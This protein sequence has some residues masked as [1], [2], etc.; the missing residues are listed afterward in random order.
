MRDH[1]VGL[2]Q[3]FGV[4]TILLGLLLA[5]AFDRLSFLQRDV[6]IH[7]AP[8]EGLLAGPVLGFT[9]ALGWT[10]CI[11]PTLGTV[12]SL[13]ASSSQASAARGA[14]LSLVYCLGLG[15][16]LLVSGLAFDRAM[17]T[18]AAIKR[19]DRLLM[20][21]GGSMLVVLGILQVTGVWN[22]WMNGLQTRFGGNSLPL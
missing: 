4:V 18:F 5:G 2:S 16:P 8:G 14:L 3:I 1:A 11:G 19:H 10:P 15:I 7:R 6:R 21:I 20:V 17:N 13:S 12:L 22:V 9:F